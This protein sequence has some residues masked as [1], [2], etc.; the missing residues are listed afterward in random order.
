MTFSSGPAIFSLRSSQLSLCRAPFL[1]LSAPQ[2]VCSAAQHLRHRA[3]VNCMLRL[4]GLCLSIP[5]PWIFTV[6][7]PA[8]KHSHS[9]YLPWCLAVMSQVLMEIRQVFLMLIQRRTCPMSYCFIQIL[10]LYLLTYVCACV[11]GNLIL[12]FKKAQ[13]YLC[14]SLFPFNLG[15]SQ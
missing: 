2:T 7:S 4:S 12:P 5:K 3:E 10:Y 1:S 13:V 6:Q 11:Y 8:L 9:L 14:L 15:G